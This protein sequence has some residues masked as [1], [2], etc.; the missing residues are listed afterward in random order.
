MNEVYEYRFKYEEGLES[1]NPDDAVLVPFRET[2][3]DFLLH[4]Y[5]VREVAVEFAYHFFSS[6]WAYEKESLVGFPFVSL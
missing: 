6:I 4:R 1:A 2:F 5:H 3:Y